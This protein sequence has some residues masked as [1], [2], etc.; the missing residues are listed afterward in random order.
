[1]KHNFV[2]LA[3]NVA[4]AVALTDYAV[5]SIMSEANRRWKQEPDPGAW[6][7][8]FCKG[9]AARIYERCEEL[10]AQAEKGEAE[11]KAPGTALVLA[12]LYEMER[13]K[14]ALVVKELGIILSRPKNR[15]KSTVVAN[16]YGAGKQFGGTVSLSRQ[17]QSGAKTAGRL[18]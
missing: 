16:G 9:A 2:G 5:S 17:V 11:A 14:N 10:R 3:G 12:S 1:M 4:T 13:M 15:T 7:T 6:W 8:S 18:T